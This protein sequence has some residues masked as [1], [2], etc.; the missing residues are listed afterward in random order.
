MRSRLIRTAH[1]IPRQVRDQ[2]GVTMILVA[3]AMVAIIAMAALS[4][5]V[6]TLYLAREEA[7]RSADAG[8][9]AAARVISISGLT[10]DPANS[11]SSWQAIC[12][13]PNNPASQAA[14]S[15]VQQNA[16]GSLVVPVPSI[17]VTYSAGSGGTKSTDCSSL[18]A[19]FGVN[20]MVTVQVARANLPTFFSRIWGNPGNK[21]S[22]TATAEAF[23]PSASD[24]NTN[25]GPTGTVTPVQPRCVKPW[26]VPNLD[27][28]NPGLGKTGYCAPGACLPLVSTADGAIQHPGI[29][30]NS[31]NIPAGVIGET[32]WLIPA[33]RFGPGSCILHNA[34]SLQPRANYNPGGGAGTFIQGPPNLMYVPGQVGNPLVAVPTCAQGDAYEEAVGGCD[35]PTNYQ[36]G[37]AGQNVVDLTIANPGASGST[38]NGV[39]CLIHQTD[40]T[41]ITS[42]SGQD[43]LNPFQAP[44]AYPFQI[45]AGTSNPLVTMASNPI[46]SG[47]TI[48]TSNSIVSLPIYDN[49]TNIQS[50]GITSVTFVGFLQVF[51]NAV[52][53]NGNVNVTVLNVAGCGTGVPV[54]TT[55]VT[56][57]SPVPVRLIT[58]P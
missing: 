44:S 34:G 43:S 10:G 41:N 6:I 14:I 51:I 31:T 26:V 23:N 37:M 35:S 22:A 58:P 39:Q 57:S 32:F 46:G 33:C 40:V 55:P 5:D 42:V 11:S 16:V 38:T 21:V 54:G 18:P 45:L 28:L 8:A 29:S 4:I 20:P 17:T 1:A 47:S 50:G 52:D 19:A 53:Q 27:P 30:L 24:N 25:G 2:R 15:V 48:S 13:P 36:C 9:L 49:S 12:G 3:L 7:Q 56:G